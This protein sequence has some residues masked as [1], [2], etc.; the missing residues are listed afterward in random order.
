MSLS[1]M[2]IHC[3]STPNTS[4]TCANGNMETEFNARMTTFKHTQKTP[5]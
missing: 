2:H 4:V 1:Q 3:S 5:Q